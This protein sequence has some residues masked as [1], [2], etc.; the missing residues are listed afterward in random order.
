MKRS[1]F[2]ILVLTVC[3]VISVPWTSINFRS[4]SGSIKELNEIGR[5]ETI[6]NDLYY[7]TTQPY[8]EQELEALA[9]LSDHYTIHL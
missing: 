8:S 7:H 3:L 5:V 9:K 2:T 1:T 6:G 4:Y